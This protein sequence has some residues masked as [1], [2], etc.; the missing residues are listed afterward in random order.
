MK[1]SSSEKGRARYEARQAARLLLPN[2]LQYPGDLPISSRKDEILATL[3]TS[4]VLV[5]AGETGSGKSTQLPK[6]CIEAGRG[7]SGMIGHTQ[8]RRIA[9]RSI[10]ERV[11]DELGVTFASPLGP[12]PVGY[13]VRFTD[14]VSDETLLKVMTDGVLLAELHGDPEL[15]TYDTLIIDEAHER[16]LNIDF[17]LG[18]LKR[19]LPARPD[20]KVIITS[21]TIDTER[22]SRHF[23]GAPVIEVSG[24]TYPVEVRYRPL[25]VEGDGADDDEPLDEVRAVCNA[26]EDLC[27]EG[28]GDV[29]V[30]LPGE[31]EIR[32]TAEALGKSG[33]ARTGTTKTSTTSLEVLA[34]YGR[35]SSQE[36]HRI[37]E[38]HTGRRAVLAT[39][40][41]ETSLTVP[42]IRFVVDLGT[43]RISRYSRRTKVQRLPIEPISQASANQRAG[44]CGRLGPGI[45][46]R[47]YSEDDFASRNAFTE[48]EIL[49]TNLAS[50]VLQMAAVGLGDIEDF[51][52]VDPPDKRNIKD[53]VALLEELGA[54]VGAAARSPSDH[55]V[56]SGLAVGPRSTEAIGGGVW[57]LTT[58]GRKLARLPLD[59]R[60][61]RMV[62]EAARLGCLEEVLVIT[63]GLSVQDPRERPADKR[64]MASALHARFTDQSSDFMSFLSLWSYLEERQAELS[65]S[66]FRRLCRKELISYQRTREWQ[67][68]VAQLVDICGQMG[69]IPRAS[70]PE[71]AHRGQRAEVH[72][73]LLSGLLTQVGVREGD[74]TDFTAPRGARFAIWP[75][76]VAAKKPPRWVMAGELVETGRLWGRVVAPVRPQW[77]ERATAHLLKW[78][79]GDPSWDEDRGS[80]FVLATATLY[81]LP[82]VTRRAVELSR[83]D[84]S[85]AR[86]M[87]IYHGLV[88]GDWAPAAQAHGALR[89][90]PSFVGENRALLDQY[91]AL[92]Q[93]ARRHDLMVGDEA[94]AEFY[95]SRLGPDVTSSTT[96]WAWWKR[97]SD[98]DRTGMTAAPED[99]WGRSST[100]LD[101]SDFPDVW[102]EAEVGPLDLEYNWEPGDED[103]GVHVVVPLAH[104]EALGR[105]GL[106]WQVPGLREELVV[107]VLRSLPKDLRRHLVPIPERAKEFVA[108]TGPKDGPLLVVLAREASTYAGTAISARD[109]DWSKVPSYLRPT[110]QVV[111]EEGQVLATG[112][113]VAELLEKLRPQLDAALQVAV[114]Q[115]SLGATPAGPADANRAD[116]DGRYTHSSSWVFGE[117]PAVFE[118]EWNGRRLRGYPALLD[119]G[120]GVSLRVFSDEPSALAAMAAGTRRLLL[121][122]LPSRRQLVDGLERRLGNRARLALAALSNPPYRS[123][124]G[125]ADDAVAASL[126][127]VVRANGGPAWGPEGFEVLVDSARRQVG[128]TAEGAVDA[129]SRILSG[130][131]DLARRAA[132]LMARAKANPSG[133]SS[134]VEAAIEDITRQLAFLVGPRFLSRAGLERLPDIERYMAAVDRRMEKLP[135][136]PRRDL[137]LTQRVKALQTRLSEAT[138]VAEQGRANGDNRGTGRLQ[139]L[140]EARW[141]I[142]ELRVSFFAQSLGTR[143]P[144][145]EQ[146]IL[147]LLNQAVPVE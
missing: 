66:Q 4:Q 25:V 5:V 67:D 50:V 56:G 1:Q 139:A 135:A 10:A 86:E 123:V 114:A 31:R 82:I 87:F 2:P 44:R 51:P 125:V 83:L 130:R 18:Y 94:L 137:A 138:S 6:M 22:F 85:L 52:F 109:F 142:E 78:T 111:G 101:A 63:A 92:L 122:N 36:Q 27:R 110:F 132:E 108:K 45:C 46:V 112:K 118:P 76:S 147:K 69:L 23:D 140:D 26:V 11:A 102:G 65:S 95:R 29:L 72:Q 24:R 60:L 54:L 58:I 129:A 98:T 144:V 17:I 89:G 75:G 77:V 73:A 104:L 121:L 103:D 43:A 62:L 116:F 84:R 70:R 32:D 88:E 145:S 141:M 97:L 38:G 47:L 131:Q 96:F 136:D 28:P 143:V 57:R 81:G 12:R 49:R 146:K 133:T 68:V 37:F 3:A 14:R 35:L 15:R 127:Q 99:L 8:P 39:N 91:R 13:K 9:A 115:A 42:G 41:A 48:P 74:R 113:E 16:S 106:E 20:L 19:L 55:A 119:E 107:A 100:G 120:D 126:D 79:Y 21:A 61:G 33:L 53:G 59:P 40:V 7:S 64:E 117:L 93:R 124:R 34:L 128:R 105:E 71:V 90:A 30:F 80:G 134:T